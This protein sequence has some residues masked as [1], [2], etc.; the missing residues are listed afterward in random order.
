MEHSAIL[1][2]C[3]MRYSDLKFSFGLLFELPLMTG[4]TVCMISM[5]NLIY[6]I[7]RFSI[8]FRLSNV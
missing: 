3:I 4:F 5:I 1:L 2:T 8:T 7:A 6:G